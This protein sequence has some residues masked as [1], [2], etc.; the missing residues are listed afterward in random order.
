MY[1]FLIH[2]DAATPYT[3]LP[4]FKNLNRAT[5]ESYTSSESRPRSGQLVLLRQ[6]SVSSDTK[7]VS[8]MAGC[9]GKVR[10]ESILRKSSVM[11]PT[12]S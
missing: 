9:E 8:K 12:G 4:C 7:G 11:E 1:T 10:W 3:L 6:L 5:R 2:A